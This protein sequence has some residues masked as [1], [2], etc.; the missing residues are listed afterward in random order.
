MSTTIEEPIIG[1]S[2]H[3]GF[4][5]VPNF[6]LLAFSAAIE[7][8]RMANQLSGKTLYKW[9]VISEGG[10]TVHASDG[11]RIEAD[12]G[13]DNEEKFDTIYVCGGVD[14]ERSDHK[15]LLRWLVRQSKAKINLGG[16][17]T[18][19]YLLAAAGL[20]DGYTC[21]IHWQYLA[22]WSEQF[23]RIVSSDHLYCIDRD[24]FTCSGGTAPMDMMLD[25][26]AREH[27]KALSEFIS[28]AF[29]YERIR[30]R[31]DVQ[32][33]PLRH[34][35][36]HTSPKLLDVVALMESNIE[37]T[38]SLDELAVYVGLSR[39][40]LERLFLQHL[41]CSPSRYYVS[42]RLSRARQLL[43]QS[44]LS[45]TDVASVCGFSSTQHF[46]GCY[47]NLYGLAPREERRGLLLS[48]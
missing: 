22:S 32:R 27:G 12:F 24:R 1:P 30:D 28:E 26:I 43:R 16:I 4:L 13:L 45:I 6:T 17:C 11:M 7:P 33:I 2:L 29:V 46:S 37:E 31:A 18:G 42:V 3:F 10:E 23:Q 38:I 47:R 48:K 44:R 34:R 14:V 40:Q 41:Q 15:T 21:T 36:G 8:L 19:S 39:R 5:M 20:L 35:A 25:V 9:S